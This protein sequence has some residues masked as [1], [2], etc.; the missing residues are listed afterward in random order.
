[1]D[2][3]TDDNHANTSTVLKHGRLNT[4]LSFKTSQHRHQLTATTR[5][6]NSNIWRATNA[7]YLLTF[8]VKYRLWVTLV[9]SK[10]SNKM[11][12]SSEWHSVNPYANLFKH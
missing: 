10:G 5:A 2:R 4:R 6:Y 8:N 3:Q 1:M 7:G 9:A 11:A 12:P